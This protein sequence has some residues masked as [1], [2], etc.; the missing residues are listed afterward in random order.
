[1]TLS[2][3]ILLAYGIPAVLGAAWSVRCGHRS[4]ISCST[5]SSLVIVVL[6]VS[7]VAL[8][9][10]GLPSLLDASSV[11]HGNM[12]MTH[13]AAGGALLLAAAV[14]SVLWVRGFAEDVPGSYSRLLPRL[15]VLLFLVAVIAT[16]LPVLLAM[17]SFF[18]TSS[19]LLL[20][21]WHEIAASVLVATSIPLFVAYVN[22]LRRPKG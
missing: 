5:I 19:Q 4:P 2:I 3:G 11:M 16:G 17:T 15:F 14:A 13:V 8:F 20:M 9:I 18:D 21:K 6:M 7:T 10:I 1:M 12:L 22:S